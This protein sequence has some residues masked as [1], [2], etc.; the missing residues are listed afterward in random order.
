MLRISVES[1]IVPGMDAGT[2]RISGEKYM[3]DEKWTGACYEIPGRITS[4]VFWDR[5]HLRT[6]GE[7]YILGRKGQELV[8]NFRGEVHDGG[9]WTSSLEELPGRST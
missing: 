3:M 4:A 2:G 8:M 7:K 5:S 9:K 6:S 1:V